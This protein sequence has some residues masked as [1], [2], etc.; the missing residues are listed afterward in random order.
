MKNNKFIKST[1]ILILGGFITKVLGF[2]IR[3]IYTRIVGEEAISLYTI[4]TPTY[5]LIITIAASF[6]PIAISKLVSENTKNNQKLL[7]NSF[8]LIMLIDII[9]ISIIILFG[10]YIAY[11][12]LKEKRTLYLIYAMAITI[13]FVSAS[14]L[15]KGYFFGKQ[16]MYP[17]VIS[18]VIEQIIR[19]F[20]IIFVIPILA[21]R[22]IILSVAGLILFNIITEI[23]SCLVFISFLPRK[24]K[25]KKDNLKLSFSYLKDILKIS[26]PLTSSRLI[27][28]I[29]FFFEPILLTNILLI[30]G[31]SNQYILSSYG[32]YN[33]Y[34][35]SLLT[36][37]NFF[38]MAISSA[39]IP[40]ISR[41]Y[42]KR[43]F[44]MIRK[45][46]KEAIYMA[47]FLGISFSLFILVFRSNLLQI[48]YKTTK[49]NEY[50]KI[51][52][53]IFVLFY[54]E[55]PLTSTLQAIG[56]SNETFKISTIGI[57]I[58]LSLMSLLAFLKLGIYSLIIAEIINIFIV[59][60]LSSL[61]VKKEL[62]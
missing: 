48:L 18:N 10:K 32:I 27:G 26:I 1:L 50:I 37:P 51:L 34:T 54:L 52:G 2:L 56:K 11:H 53:P 43:N 16:K 13:P 17:N 55:G 5:S 57:I 20:L 7:F 44:K 35:I 58:K 14:S 33:A 49:G 23:I 62:F 30:K 28:N 29:G 61:K 41:F 3:I 36:I 24:A 40:E 19:V 39:I 15:F 42:A 8:L 4:I 60:I 21:K 22:N 45:R 25:L 59:V 46:F 47:L 31:F 6:L 9:L 12:L 38:I